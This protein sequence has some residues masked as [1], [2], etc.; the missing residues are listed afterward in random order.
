MVVTRGYSWPGPGRAD[1]TSARLDAGVE[2]S[3]PH[4]FAVREQ[5]SVVST[6]LIAHRPEPALRSRRALMR[7]RVHRIPPRVRDDRD[8]PLLGDETARDIDLIWVRRETKYFCKRDWTGGIR[9]IPFNKSA[10]ARR[11]V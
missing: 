11:A 2:A 4:D 5:A 1:F 9:L 7:C 3:G 8:A 10:G 6:P